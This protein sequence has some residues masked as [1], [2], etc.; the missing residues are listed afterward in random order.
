MQRAVVGA[1]KSD[2]VF[3]GMPAAVGLATDVM[4]FDV[5]RVTAARKDAAM[6]VAA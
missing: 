3:G 2:Q 1:T 5:G 6:L 4:H